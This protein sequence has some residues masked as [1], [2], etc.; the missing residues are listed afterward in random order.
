M[1]Y[2]TWLDFTTSEWGW[3]DN[4]WS[5]LFWW[6]PPL[7]Q[8]CIM[9]SYKDLFLLKAW[10]MKRPMA[11]YCMCTFVF[12]PEWA[13]DSDGAF[14]ELTHKYRSLGV[15]SGL[16]GTP[17]GSSSLFLFLLLNMQNCLNDI[18]VSFI[19]EV[20]T[21]LF[22]HSNLL[23]HL[24]FLSKKAKCLLVPA[25]Y[26]WEFRFSLSIMIVNEESLRFRLKRLF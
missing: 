5:F 18:C 13:C 11:V 14:Q 21:P 1:D 22:F 19:S 6:T 17:V 24:A 4:R 9:N 26:M 16:T 7:M 20:Q 3:V 2:N 23:F 15:Q 8:G 25:S 12:L 10:K